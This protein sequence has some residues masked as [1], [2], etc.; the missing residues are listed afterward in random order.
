MFYILHNNKNT[1]LKKEIEKVIPTTTVKEYQL[2]DG[3]IFSGVM[4]IEDSS[5][6]S[7]FPKKK[8]MKRYKGL[9]VYPNGNTFHGYWANDVPHTG[10][11]T[12]INDV[13][14]QNKYTSVTYQ[15]YQGKSILVFRGSI[16][17][18]DGSKYDGHI[19]HK[20]L[21]QIT[22]QTYEFIVYRHGCNGRFIS[23]NG[24]EIYGKW[25]DDQLITLMIPISN[26]KNMKHIK[27]IY[28]LV[29]ISKINNFIY[30][31]L[32]QELTETELKQLGDEL[33][34]KNEIILENTLMDALQSSNPSYSQ[35]RIDIKFSPYSSMRPILQETLQ[36]L[37][38]KQSPDPPQQ[39]FIDITI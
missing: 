10:N 11:F 12:E 23:P 39:A 15:F 5:I 38:R 28:H 30:F 9:N 18:T 35:P 32:T 3:S 4:R 13:R 6:F 2:K 22:N 36:F 21:D 8:L 25:F 20:Y 34:T 19:K 16:V 7:F 37:H 27:H 31:N 17:Y 26:M 14:F 29:E 33:Y 24:S 1:K